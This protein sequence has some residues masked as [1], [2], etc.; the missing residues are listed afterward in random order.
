LQRQWA[1]AAAVPEAE[2]VVARAVPAG[3]VAAHRSP[4]TGERG[5]DAC[6]NLVQASLPLDTR[7]GFELAPYGL[8]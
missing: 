8:M 6:T 5:K 4:T 2:A 3:A 7:A 1:S